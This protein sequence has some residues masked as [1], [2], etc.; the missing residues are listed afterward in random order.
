MEKN[1][2][3][4]NIAGAGKKQTQINLQTEKW[5]VRKKVEE[6]ETEAEKEVEEE[7]EAK[8]KEE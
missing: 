3:G 1:C 8:K 2:E 5:M 4:G 7:E 6:E